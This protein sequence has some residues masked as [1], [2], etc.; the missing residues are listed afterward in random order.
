[1]KPSGICL[2]LT[3][4]SYLNTFVAH[5]CCCIW[6]DL[7]FMI[8]PYSIVYIHHFFI[9]LPIDGH[10]RCFHILAIVNYAAISIWMYMSF[11]FS[12]LGCSGYPEVEL[13]GPLF[14][15][16]IIFILKYILPSINITTP[17]FC[18]ISIFM[19]YLFPALYFESVYVF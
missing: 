2:S 18:F 17:A 16:H 11:Q 6:Q 1:M 7:F 15:L 10:L 8:Q 3:N 12:V 14:Y 5:P 9:H 19:K 4:F 13:V